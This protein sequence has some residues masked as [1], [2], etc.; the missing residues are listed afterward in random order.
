MSR[1]LVGKI[2]GDIEAVEY[3]GNQKYRCRCIKCGNISEKF[4]S[5]LKGTLS[6]KECGDG[7]KVNLT[8]NQ[9]GKLEVKLYNKETKKWICQCECGRFIEVKSNNLKSGN[10]SSCGVC[11]YKDLAARCIVQGT[12][13]TQLDV[14]LRKNNTSGVTGVG[15]H[16]RKGKW[17]ACIRFRGIVYWLGYYDYIQDAIDARKEAETKLHGDFMAWYNATKEESKK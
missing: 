1:S 6:C 14:G 10:T 9:Y 5:N 13:V 8:G 12:R 7:F 17:Y 16:K 15:F 4:S 2:Y 11:G 3:I